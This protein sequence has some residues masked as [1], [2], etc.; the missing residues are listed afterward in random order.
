MPRPFIP[1]PMICS[2]DVKVYKYS[3]ECYRDA[4]LSFGP[5][6]FEC[7]SVQLFKPLGLNLLASLIHNLQLRGREIMFTPP[8]DTKAFQYLTD[9]GF[10]NEFQF[11]SGANIL[12]QKKRSTSV[13]LRR[14]DEFVGS[15]PNQ[16]AEWLSIN[17]STPHEAVMDM[18]AVTLP[19]IMNNVFDHSRSPIGCCVCAQAYQAEGQLAMSVTDLGVGFL[20]SLQPCYQNLNT[21]E[22]AITLAI[23]EGV[24]SKSSPRNRGAGLY[25]LSDW[26][27]EQGG[28]LEIISM[29]GRW[30]LL[31]G[32]S[33]HH[34]TIP[35]SFPGTC[36][37]LSV[38][39][40]VLLTS[41]GAPTNE[42]YD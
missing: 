6:I 17:S 42:R 21:D 25:I 23:K 10:F 1:F 11:I 24:S 29:D 32:G 28:E 8:K 31:T 7:G 15:Y 36:I 34:E 14:M 30:R 33:V 5:V 9:Q 12:K 3:V 35:F 40:D 2:E 27:K 41:M 20:A 16:I 13:M 38:P 26:L 37:N 18:V 22:E 39:T 4:L 19:E